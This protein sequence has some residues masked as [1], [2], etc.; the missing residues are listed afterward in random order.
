M[1]TPVSIIWVL[2]MNALLG[3]GKQ[4]A[5]DSAP[6]GEIAQAHL[7]AQRYVDPKGYFTILPPDGWQAQ[8]YPQDPRG[9]VA[10]RAPG[11]E[12]Y[13][14]ILVNAQDF[15]SLDSLVAMC[16]EIENRI[17][18]PSH[19]EVVELA[20]APVVRR[21]FQAQ[22]YRILTYDLLV[23]SVVHNLQYAAPPDVYPRYLPVV[24][25]SME[26]YEA[27]QRNTSEADFVAHKVAKK[28]RQAQLAIDNGNYD[29]ASA[30]L[31]EGLQYAPGNADLL[32]LR[33]QIESR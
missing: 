20:G 10:F 5:G 15:T 23:G 16:R 25:K 32:K 4:D 24:I 28:I 19:I 29:L 1:P 26:S 21:S 3:C 6:T 17:G 9:K 22:G 31:Q 11:G 7:A 13:F 27:T 8:E 18:I 33:K 30:Y 14:R 12:D 2:L